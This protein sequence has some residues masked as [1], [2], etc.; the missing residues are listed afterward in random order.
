MPKADPSALRVR[1]FLKWAGNKTRI[2]ERVRA[3]LPEGQRLVEPFVGSGAVF[4]NTDYARYQLSDSNDDLI[5]LYNLVKKEGPAFIDY[6]RE[7]FTPET[8]RETAYYALREEFNA[9]NDPLRRAALFVYFNRHGYNGLCRYNRSGGFN[10]PFGRYRRPYFPAAEM[11]AFH[12]KARR[13]TFRREDFGATMAK[14]KTGDVVYCDPPYVP[15]SPSSNFTAY[16]AG[17]FGP[18][19]QDRLVQAARSAAARGIPVLISNHDTPLCRDLYAGSVMESFPV[20][21]SISCNGE[22]R[23]KVA[24]L[25]ALYCTA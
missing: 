21:R 3:K 14:V 25:L 7:L 20:Q 5:N 24:E 12:R 18:T 1:P 6:C 13:A 4:L 11:L 17:G 2:V 10:V 22:K 9:T 8:N 15:L 19:E 16:S 23:N